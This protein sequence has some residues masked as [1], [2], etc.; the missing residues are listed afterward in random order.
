MTYKCAYLPLNIDFDIDLDYDE[1]NNG[2]ICLTTKFE[3]YMKQCSGAIL[4]VKESDKEKL[5]ELVIKQL[6]VFIEDNHDLMKFCKSN[7]LP[8]FVKPFIVE[9]SIGFNICLIGRNYDLN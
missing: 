8:L 4:N 7:S 2:R 9:D 1:S 5:S 6:L 3:G